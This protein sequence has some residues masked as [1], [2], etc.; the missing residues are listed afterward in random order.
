MQFSWLLQCV[1]LSLFNNM[2]ISQNEKMTYEKVMWEFEE[3]VISWRVELLEFLYGTEINWIFQTFFVTDLKLISQRYNCSILTSEI[4]RWSKNPWWQRRLMK[5]GGLNLELSG[6]LKLS[7]I[8]QD[9]KLRKQIRG[10]YK[11]AADQ[12]EKK[13]STGKYLEET[14]GK[15]ARECREKTWK[16]S[17]WTVATH[18]DP[19][20]DQSLETSI[21][22]RHKNVFTMTCNQEKYKQNSG[23]AQIAKVKFYTGTIS[24]KQKIVNGQFH[25]S[26]VKV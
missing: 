22:T 11:K 16:E 14:S 4:R 10:R 20:K 13:P 9:R 18:I 24:K 2:Q 25:K 19:G 17:A 12:W 15:T 3:T 6:C 23:A 5:H 8:T 1:M 7:K 21:S 26:L